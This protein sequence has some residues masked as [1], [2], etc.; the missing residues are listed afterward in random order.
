MSWCNSVI[1]LRSQGCLAGTV[2]AT[3]STGERPVTEIA[4][5]IGTPWQGRGM[6]TEA[7]GALITWLGEHSVQTVIAHIHPATG[8]PPLSLPPLANC[9][10]KPVSQACLV[11]AGTL[12]ADPSLLNAYFPKRAQSNYCAACAP[13]RLR[14]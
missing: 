8:H 13:L 6:A 9:P 10:D 2:Q 12:R 3:I 7:A 1:Q 5:V 11:I 4:W 14:F